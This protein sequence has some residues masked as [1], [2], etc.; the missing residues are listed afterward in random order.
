[1]EYQLNP[2]KLLEKA[3]ELLEKASE[4]IGDPELKREIEEYL[5]FRN[6][7]VIEFRDLCMWGD[8]EKARSKI[9][10]LGAFGKVLP[11]NLNPYHLGMLSQNVHLRERAI[12]TKIPAMHNKLL[13]ADVEEI[14]DEIECNGSDTLKLLSDESCDLETHVA[15]INNILEQRP[16]VGVGDKIDMHI[17]SHEKHLKLNSIIQKM[18]LLVEC[19]FG[20]EVMVKQVRPLIEKWRK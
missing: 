18:R 17:K 14:L 12:H 4:H 19:R 15:F 5:F 2:E 6:I 20:T 10:A 13:I 16:L 3:S 9:Q 7:N 11:N 1:M 8:V